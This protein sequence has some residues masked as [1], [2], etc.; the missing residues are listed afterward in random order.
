MTQSHWLGLADTFQKNKSC[1][2]AN[3]RMPGS[4]SF[5]RSLKASGEKGQ[6]RGDPG[7]R[8]TLHC[9]LQFHLG[10]RLRGLFPS[11]WS[12]LVGWEVQEAPVPFCATHHLRQECCRKL[13]GMETGL[14][15]GP[16]TGGQQLD[17]LVT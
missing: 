2:V 8:V 15:C 6:V 1:L 16:L 9:Q 3:S 17:V 12:A 13:G 11:A 14:R 4:G 7:L 10:R 5:L